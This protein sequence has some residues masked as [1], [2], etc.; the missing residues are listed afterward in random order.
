M[1]HTHC[2]TLGIR[3][4]KTTPWAFVVVFSAA[5]PSIVQ[6]PARGV[7][8]H[9]HCRELSAET[10]VCHA[11]ASFRHPQGVCSAHEWIELELQPAY[12]MCARPYIS[13]GHVLLARL[14][15]CL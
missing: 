12:H 4:E 3:Y 10:D 9:W 1:F 6:C 11:F 8:C 5:L 13:H 15:L 14:P 7:P 2:F